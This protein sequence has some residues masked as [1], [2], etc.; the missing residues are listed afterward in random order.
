MDLGIWTHKINN[1]NIP[2]DIKETLITF[3]TNFKLHNSLNFIKINKDTILK[4]LNNINNY[5]HILLAMDAEFQTTINDLKYVRELGMLI[6]VRDKG[7]MYYYVGYIF[8]NFPSVIKFGVKI[9]DMRP[10][11][12]TYATVTDKIR[13]E[14]E[15]NESVLMLDRLIDGMDNDKLFRDKKEWV[16][17]VDD[18]IENFNND[19]IYNNILNDGLK[20]SIIVSLNFIKGDK[21]FNN[22][23]TELKML[24]KRLMKVK[25]DIF[26]QNI[27]GTPLYDNFLKSHQLYWNDSYVVKRI[28]LLNGKHDLFFDLFSKLS[29]SSMFMVKGVQD[30]DALNNTL[31][32]FKYNVKLNFKSYYDIEIF[33][34]LSNYLYNSSQLET[35]YENIIKL[36]V[37]KQF[38]KPIFDIII[39]NVG[40]RAHNPV[41]DSLFTIIVAVTMNIVLLMAMKDK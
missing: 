2:T 5:K 10:V 30:F 36:K 27:K 23:C 12:T 37:Y 19:W 3:F 32:L 24:K 17:K 8:L 34:G 16:T 1:L 41:A 18:V 31:A 20:K 38:A 22:V 13:K 33:N 9:D 15:D 21:N 39:K 11:Y 7:G 29:D 4:S 35:T 26:G 25:F 14:M 6:F 40:N 28:D